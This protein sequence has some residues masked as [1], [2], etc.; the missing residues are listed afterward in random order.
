MIAVLG[1][2]MLDTFFKFRQNWSTDPTFFKRLGKLFHDN[3]AMIFPTNGLFTIISGHDQLTL[4]KL[5]DGRGHPRPKS[6]LSCQ[7]QRLPKQ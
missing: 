4:T 5:V 1:S 2:D 3:V 7:T 6:P